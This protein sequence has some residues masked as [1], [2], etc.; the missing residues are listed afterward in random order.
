MLEVY[1]SVAMLSIASGTYVAGLY[2]MNVLNGLEEAS[3]GF[4]L[5]TGGSI[6]AMAWFALVGISRVRRISRVLRIHGAEGGV[7]RKGVN[8][9]K[10]M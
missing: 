9:K 5:T 2:G 3:H 6:I 1:F 4:V 8:G 10:P 7:A